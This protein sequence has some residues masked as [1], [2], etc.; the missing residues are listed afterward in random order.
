MCILILLARLALTSGTVTPLPPEAYLLCFMDKTTNCS[1]FPDYLIVRN[2]VEKKK[3]LNL[4][5]LECL[6]YAR[7]GFYPLFLSH[8]HKHRVF[9][10]Q[11]APSKEC[12][13][14]PGTHTYSTLPCMLP[15]SLPAYKAFVRLLPECLGMENYFKKHCPR[16]IDFTFPAELVCFFTMLL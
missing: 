16:F 12:D 1:C 7:S 4:A 10:M 6:S 11:V 9:K 2:T 15:P 14:V 5:S 13:K 3:V 8:F